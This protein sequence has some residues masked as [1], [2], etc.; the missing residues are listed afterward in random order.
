MPSNSACAKKQ[1]LP[2]CDHLCINSKVFNQFRDSIILFYTK[3]SLNQHSLTEGVKNTP[4][5][6]T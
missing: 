2:F 4:T 1:V 6:D 3:N 5:A